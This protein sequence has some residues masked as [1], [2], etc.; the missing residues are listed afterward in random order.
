MDEENNTELKDK[1]KISF[2]ACPEGVNRA[3]SI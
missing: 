3:Y 2:V 1:V